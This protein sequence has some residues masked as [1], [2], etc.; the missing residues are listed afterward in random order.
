[1]RE[2]LK[3]NAV[4]CFLGI[5]TRVFYIINQVIAQIIN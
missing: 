4:V 5:T 3:Q 2:E 1:M